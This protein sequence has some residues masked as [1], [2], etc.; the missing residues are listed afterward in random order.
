M[1]SRQSSD[2][3]HDHPGYVREALSEHTPIQNKNVGRSVPMI[4]RATT[5]VKSS[6][7]WDNSTVAT[8]SHIYTSTQTPAMRNG[9]RLLVLMTGLTYASGLRIPLCRIC[10]HLDSAI[11]DVGANV[12]G[13]CTVDSCRTSG[14]FQRFLTESA[15]AL[16]SNATLQVDGEDVVL[17]T[18]SPNVGA[19]LLVLAFLGRQVLDPFKQDRTRS[20]VGVLEYDV[21]AQVFRVTKPLCVFQKLLY[22]SLLIVTIAVVLCGVALQVIRRARQPEEAGGPLPGATDL[23]MNLQA[24]Y[25]LV[26]SSDSVRERR[27]PI[28]P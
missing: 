23:A 14:K 20:V 19:E 4:A 22:E 5:S 17:P 18:D 27:R 3:P 21:G 9:C 25:S 1:N 13:P 8:Q 16:Q 26:L 12:G 10:E 11:A 6:F 7:N 15:A 28:G 24:G 2:A